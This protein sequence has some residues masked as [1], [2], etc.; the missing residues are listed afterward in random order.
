MS[1]A[2]GQASLLGFLC[3]MITSAEPRVLSRQSLS[4]YVPAIRILMHACGHLQP[5]KTC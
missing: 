3:K 5:A 1:I 2:G 4:L